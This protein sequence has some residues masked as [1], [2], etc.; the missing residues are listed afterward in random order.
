MIRLKYPLISLYAPIGAMASAIRA[1]HAVFFF[2]LESF[3]L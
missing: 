1:R 3:N 2:I